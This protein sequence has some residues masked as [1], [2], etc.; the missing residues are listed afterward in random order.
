MVVEHVKEKDT[1]IS[2]NADEIIKLLSEK[3][4]CMA[5]RKGPDGKISPLSEKTYKRAC[6]AADVV[7]VEADGSKHMPLKFP[8]ENEPVIPDNTDRI[9]V[10]M[11]LHGIGMKCKDAVHR[12]ELAERALGISKDTVIEQHH[13][14]DIIRTGYTEPLRRKYP[15]AEIEVK[16]I[17]GL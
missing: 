6:R 5:G 7:L 15:G 9:V 2:D 10:I 14:D 1:L 13:I 12:Y 4:Y 3:S 16:K 17:K 8:S 11:G